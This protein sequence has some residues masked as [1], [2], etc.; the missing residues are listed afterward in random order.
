MIEL[1]LSSDGKHTVHVSADDAE[2]MNKL[3]PYAR[4]LYERVLKQFGTK[5]QMWETAMNGKANGEARRTNANGQ[6]NGQARVGRRMDTVEQARQA[7]APRCVEHGTPMRYRNGRYGAF[8]S[9]P[10][11]N[12]DGSWCT[13][14]EQVSRAGDGQA[15]ATVA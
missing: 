1:F 13:C 7:M 10:R 11:K 14:T 5:A 3:T 15:Q 12:P 9:C 8:W 6:P 2:Q 4:A